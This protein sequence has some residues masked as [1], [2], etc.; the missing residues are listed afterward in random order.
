MPDI[1]GP[2]PGG[3]GTLPQQM[4]TE[5]P[6]G[7]QA[8]GAGAPAGG[9]MATPQPKLGEQMK[10][11]ASIEM[12]MKV[13]YMSGSAFDPMSEESKSIRKAMDILSKAFGSTAHEAKELVP[14]EISQLMSGMK[15]PGG[16]GPQPGTPAPATGGM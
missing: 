12:A 3:V 4:P 14:T 6:G 9:P 16:G 10:A 7:V 1:S 5:T 15:P 11:K 2:G 8:P 13:L